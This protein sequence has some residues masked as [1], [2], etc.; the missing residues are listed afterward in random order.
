MKAR[1]FAPI[2]WAITPL[3]LATAA[4]A[5]PDTMV[6]TIDVTIELKDIT[7]AEAATRFATIEADLEAALAERMVDRI[8]ETGVNVIIDISELELSNSFTEKL[9]LAD[10][11]LVADVKI[12]DEADNSNFNTYQLTVDVNAAKMYFPEGTDVTILPA[13]SSVYYDAM[14]IAFADAVVKGLDEQN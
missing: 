9:N 14:I 8:A 6:K 4:G 13:D 2:L 5:A 1:R 3:F 7:N 10:T 12:T 11:R